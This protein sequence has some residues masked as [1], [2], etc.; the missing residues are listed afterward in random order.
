MLLAD[1]G[2]KVIK[3]EASN[4]DRMAHLTKLVETLTA[5]L[6]TRTTEEWLQ[7]FHVGQY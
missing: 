5:T 3:I 4:T 2:A 7:V 1:L 6:K